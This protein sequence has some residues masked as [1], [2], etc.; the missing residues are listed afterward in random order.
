MEDAK[1]H[2]LSI[3]HIHGIVF[4]IVGRSGTSTALA[5]LTLYHLH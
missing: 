5:V 3:L 4:I 1:R 2:V